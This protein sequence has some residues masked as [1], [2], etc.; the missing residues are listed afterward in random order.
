MEII[1]SSP[2]IRD[3]LDFINRPE[4]KEF[5]YSYCYTIESGY[6]IGNAIEFRKKY[7]L[8]DSFTHHIVHDRNYRNYGVYIYQKDLY[9][10]REIQLKFAMKT[11]LPITNDCLGADPVNTKLLCDFSK[12]YAESYKLLSDM[13]KKSV[14]DGC[15]ESKEDKESED[16]EAEFSHEVLIFRNGKLIHNVNGNFNKIEIEDSEDE[17]VITLEKLEENE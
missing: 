5:F 3:I 16:D 1:Y 15:A 13:F 7:D 10:F 6:D 11:S 17:L 2:D 8:K 9:I 12:S 14:E 4:Y